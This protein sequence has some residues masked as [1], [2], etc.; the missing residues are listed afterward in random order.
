MDVKTL[1]LGVLTLGEM[2]GYQIKKRFEDELSHFF[3]ASFGSIY[4]ALA[5]LAERGLVTVRDVFQDRRPHKKI[6]AITDQG[7]E[8]L[9]EALEETEASHRVRSELFTLLYFAHRLDPALLAEKLVRRMRD[10]RQVLAAVDAFES[11]PH[12]QP[13]RSLVAGLARATLESQLTGLEAITDE[14]PAPR[15]GVT[16]DPRS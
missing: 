5:D 14:L 15:E 9:D 3:P 13:S 1:C 10:I 6:Y 16:T 2:T 4:P 12:P 11:G 8:A 7:R